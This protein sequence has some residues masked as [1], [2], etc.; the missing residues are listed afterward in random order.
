MTMTRGQQAE[1]IIREVFQLGPGTNLEQCLSENNLM[2][3]KKWLARTDAQLEALQFTDP[4][5]A[6]KKLSLKLGDYHEFRVFC[7]LVHHRRANGKPAN[8]LGIDI[9]A[10]EF[11]D[12]DGSNE[13]IKLMIA[14]QPMPTFTQPPPSNMTT[15]QAELVTFRKGIKRDASLFPVIKQDTEWDS[16][17]RS[18]VSIART[19]NIDQVLDSDYR[20]VLV[21]EV[22][23]FEEKQKY[24][25][26]VFE[27]TMQTDKGKAIVRSH[28]AT[29]DA[30]KV[31]K[32]MHHYCVSSTRALLNSSTLLAYITSAKLGDGAWKSNSTKFIL[33]WEEQVR[34]YATLVPKSDHF[35]ESI[36]LQ[37]LQNA[38]HPILELRQI[39][40]QADQLHTQ[41]GKQIKY[42][43][44]VGLL[45]S[46]SAQY[47]SQFG[48]ASGTKLAQKRQVYSHQLNLE[49][50]DDYD[51]DTPVSVIQAH[52]AMR[53]EA[54]MPGFTWS[55][56]PEGDRA[57]WDQLSD[58]TKIAILGA[59]SQ[60]KPRTSGT[61]PPGKRL[62]QLCD[63]H[64]AFQ[65]LSEWSQD[66]GEETPGTVIEDGGPDPHLN[67]QPPED[68]PAPDLLTFATYCAD[69]ESIP[70]AHLAR[71]MS[72]AVNRHSKNKPVPLRKTKVA[73]SHVNSSSVLYSVFRSAHVSTKGAALVD[74]GSNGGL[75]GSE[76]RVIDTHDNGHTVNIEGINRHRM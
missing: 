10:N 9:T 37:M 38:V 21:D 58:D 20:P 57:I 65:H 6:N 18:I 32:E 31:Y 73:I 49:P 67:E 16:W 75:A 43:E 42:A 41:M 23:L 34:Q 4:N 24:M 30:Q 54:M 40:I 14:A 66:T 39:K 8:Y 17:N 1:K 15:T 33:H 26:A 11:D 74:G 7:I 35:P 63:V 13:C 76:M 12:F 19:Q 70:P 3:I 69:S 44:Y 59:R 28:E 68:S 22:S 56:I 72:D 64:Q 62:V 51:V 5:D 29:F 71:M 55:K 27:R 25:Y 50:D 46:A 47:N 48:T 36:R 61:R 2:Y 53:R 52:K 60:T 45:Y